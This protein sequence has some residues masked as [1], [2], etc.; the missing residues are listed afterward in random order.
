MERN[1]DQQIKRVKSS[2]GKAWVD[3]GK[4][5]HFHNDLNKN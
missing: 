4:I 5:N 1:T 3:G 2:S